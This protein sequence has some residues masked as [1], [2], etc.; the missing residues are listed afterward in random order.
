LS[1]FG[2]C[3]VYNFVFLQIT[4]YTDDRRVVHAFLGVPY[5]AAPTGD[6]R[7]A[8]SNITH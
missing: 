4:V 6:L 3:W 5:A 7:F 8:V 1:T 2:I